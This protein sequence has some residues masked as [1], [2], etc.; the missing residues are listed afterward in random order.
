MIA[1]KTPR[2]GGVQPSP[3][4]PPV[5]LMFP[6]IELLCTITPS[7]ECSTMFPETTSWLVSVGC[8]MLG[9]SMQGNPVP[10]GLALQPRNTTPPRSTTRFPVTVRLE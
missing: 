3:P 9:S 1:P 5:S 10:S 6:P 8:F 7:G 4:P 2:L